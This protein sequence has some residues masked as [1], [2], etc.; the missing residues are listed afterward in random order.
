VTVMFCGSAKGATMPPYIVYKAMN[1]Y[2]SWTRGGAEGD[3]L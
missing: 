2:D 3:P 1:L